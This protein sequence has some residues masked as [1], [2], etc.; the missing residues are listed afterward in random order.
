MTSDG[1]EAIDTISLASDCDPERFVVHP[2]F[3]HSLM[4]VARFVSNLCGGFNE[5]IHLQSNWLSSNIILLCS[6]QI[7]AKLRLFPL[8]QAWLWSH[9]R[10]TSLKISLG[11]T[12]PAGS[13]VQP[14]SNV[15]ECLR[16]ILS[17]S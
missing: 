2:L 7:T 1:M 14:Y 13:P 11:Y 4:H 10:F 5:C 17:H 12:F 9:P 8:V 16:K 15:C 6:I 3:P